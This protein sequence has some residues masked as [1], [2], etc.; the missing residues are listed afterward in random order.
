MRRILL[1]A[2]LL[3]TFP[4]LTHAACTTPT[5]ESGK[6]LYNTGQKVLTYC[7]GSTWK[8]LGMPNPGGGTS[9][10][11]P[12]G[13]EGMVFFNTNTKVLEYC[14][15]TNW[16][17]MGNDN[18]GGGT[19][20]TTPTGT[21]GQVI[22]NPSTTNLQYCNGTSWINAAA[23][24]SQWTPANLAVLPLVWIDADDPAT[25]SKNGSNQM[26]SWTNK[27]TGANFTQVTG[28]PT[29]TA[30][31][32]PGGNAG[33]SFAVSGQF[34]AAPGGFNNPNPIFT[35]GVIKRTGVPSAAGA[36]WSSNWAN[37][38]GTTGAVFYAT[39][40]YTNSSIVV[41]GDA[42]GFNA[43]FNS[44]AISAPTAN[45]TA[46]P[47]IISGLMGSAPTPY[48]RYDGAAVTTRTANALTTSSGSTTLILGIGGGSEGLYGYVGTMVILGYSPTAAEYQKLEG[49]AAWKY[50]MQ[51]SLPS[52][53]PYRYSAP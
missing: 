27:G 40:N 36:L 19:A 17:N 39:G 12:T 2:L 38:S 11:S 8:N 28:T 26:T 3:L 37:A 32:F 6:V 45:D 49:W 16:V 34:M 46:S 24:T 1:A 48:L 15:G 52:G 42:F 35:F 51:S 14:N 25:I 23:W 33:V 4:A 22:Y 53:H 7:A 47:H 29:W 41:A 13:P 31:V 10:S 20:C 30:S 44:T 50:G 9:C 43:G 18:T 5:G 21:P